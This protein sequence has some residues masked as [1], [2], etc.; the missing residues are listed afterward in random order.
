[1]PFCA[2][3]PSA[4]AANL[5]ALFEVAPFNVISILLRCI[6]ARQC[7][8]AIGR[9]KV[10]NRREGFQLKVQTDLSFSFLDSEIKRLTCMGCSSLDVCV[11]VCVCF[12]FS[13]FF[14]SHWLRKFGM[15]PFWSSWDS[16]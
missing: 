3:T 12:F 1:M 9:V 16:L 15:Q 4:V 11:S 5:T 8:H 13:F 14:R 7:V 10:Q 2:A 6:S